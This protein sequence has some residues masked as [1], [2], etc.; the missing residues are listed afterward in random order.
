MNKIDN[1]AV[2]TIRFLS[3]DAIQKAKSGHPGMPVGAA[4]IAWELWSKHM[5][6]NPKNPGWDNRDRFILS[7]GHASMLEYSL[8]HIFGYGLPMDEIKNFRQWGSLTPGHP[9]YRHT[10]GVEATS[11]PLGQGIAMGAG[12]ALAESHLA[13]VFNRPGFDIVDHNTYV[14]CGDGC[15][16]EGVSAEAA[17]FAGA[18]GLSKLT[19][20]YDCNRI[21]IE[22]S[23]D[24]TFTENVKG[25][26]EAYGWQV[27]EVADGNNDIDGIGAA[28]EKAKAETGKPSLIIVRTD[29]A[30]GVPEK[31]GT[32]A[33][34]GAPFGEDII[35][36]WKE[37]EG[38]GHPAFTVPGEVAEHV[39]ALLE[40]FAR[41]ESEWQ[42]LFEDYR[43]AY[44]E[45]A[46]KYDSYRGPVDMGLFKDDYWEAGDESLATRQ[47][48]AVILGRVA[49]IMPNLI[50]GSADLA[51]ANNT[52]MKAREWYS[53]EDRT[54]TNIHFGI[55]EF[56][57]AAISNGLALHGGLRPYCATFLVFIDYLKGAMRLAALM[58]LP[59]TYV[60]THDSIAVGEDG[61]THEPIE[62]LASLR[63]TP[64]VY[65]WRPADTRETAAAWYFAASGRGPTAIALSRQPAA[66]QEGTGKDALKGA[67]I[68]REGSAE[69]DVILIATGTEV[70][71]ALQAHEALKQEGISA[72]VVS[73]PCMELFEEQD[74]D[75][76]EKV[77]PSKVRGRVAIEAGAS[78]GWAKYAGD[79]GAYVTIDGFGASAPAAVLLEKFGFT[80][81]NVV[82]K[83]KESIGK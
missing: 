37:R 49:E 61:P 78:F 71:I 43:K 6:H 3:A 52:Q 44:P 60:L 70:G 53:P 33:A 83:A 41:A 64:G 82:K 56:A 27:I 13:A 55:R 12:F 15:M 4:P 50:G 42:R 59:V 58:N 31:Q 8:L 81:D 38:W 7:A 1:L 80:A 25:R 66:Q 29:I 19:L 35:S 77:I 36:R 68:L 34:H 2:N 65:T 23:I 74:E 24:V 54:G 73:M 14:L 16:E 75:Y 21:T 46:D 20:I 26:Y 10:A 51:P 79:K 57:M 22:G 30:H 76:R 63:A 5:K 28:I 72:R 40:G 18:L 69:P 48:S 32:A 11:G 9:E 39:A 67:Y 47:S 62:Q 45:L 17:S